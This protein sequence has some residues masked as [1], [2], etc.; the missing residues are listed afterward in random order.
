[1]LSSCCRN[2]GFRIFHDFDFGIGF[3]RVPLKWDFWKCTLLASSDDSVIVV[4]TEL[5][6][7]LNFG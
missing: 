5:L 2:D 7:L 4:D 3:G 6:L 1:M